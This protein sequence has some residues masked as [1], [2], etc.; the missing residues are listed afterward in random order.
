MIYKPKNQGGMPDVLNIN[1]N[2][3]MINGHLTEKYSMAG[4]QMNNNNGFFEL[5]G[6]VCFDQD[7]TSNAKMSNA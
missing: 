1:Q 3:A 2:K 7:M 6:N 4:M 5:S